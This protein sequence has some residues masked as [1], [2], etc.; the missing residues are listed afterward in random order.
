MKAVFAI[1][2]ALAMAPHAGAAEMS[3][4]EKILQGAMTPGTGDN[5]RK[6]DSGVAIR[7]LIKHGYLPRKPEPRADYVDYRL[8]RKP[9]ALFGHPV[10]VIEEEYLSTYIGCCVNP[11]IGLIIEK[12]GNTTKLDAFLSSNKCSANSPLGPEYAMDLVGLKPNSDATY[13][14]IS[15]RA[16]N[17]TDK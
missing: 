12:A 14:S 4:A 17:L 6:I 11:G 5:Q 10:L 15:C 3:D 16:W 7:A 8:L 13:I 9:L 1:L 2:I